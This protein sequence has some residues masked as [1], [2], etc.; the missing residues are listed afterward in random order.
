[1]L[2]PEISK[3]DGIRLR[4]LAKYDVLDTS[5]E[6]VFDRITR[7]ASKVAGVPISLISLVDEE[8]QWFKS[9]YGL[10]TEETP[11]DISFCGHAIHGNEPFVVPDASQDERFAD[12]P[13]VSGG[14]GIRLYAGVPLKVASGA[15]LGTLCVIDKVARNLEADEITALRDLAAIAV[16]ELELR[17]LA[18]TDSLTGAFNR[19]MLERIGAMELSRARRHEEY[20]CYAVLDL[21]HFRGVN[22][23]HGHD[24]GDLVLANIAEI[25]ARHLRREDSLFRLGGEEFGILFA[26][27][28]LEETKQTLTRLLRDIE[29]NPTAVDG[30]D[31]HMTASIGLT[32]FWPGETSMNDI[33][34]RADAALDDA[35][36][37]GRNVVMIG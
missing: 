32:E 8:R 37:A 27:A 34:G 24:G 29:S 6:E 5:R 1:M 23:T 7:I 21:D 3:D 30:K 2:T 20:F 22:D 36:K 35:K 13:L 25:C 4:L 31:I 14:L 9:R 10:E 18:L 26:N 11:R 19:R 16:R 15:N 33:A 28:G 17:K 12:N